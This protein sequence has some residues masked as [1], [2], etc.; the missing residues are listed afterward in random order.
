MLVPKVTM[1]AKSF[2]SMLLKLIYQ[3]T[4]VFIILFFSIPIAR[5]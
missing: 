4:I 5:I 1:D 3:T 2:F